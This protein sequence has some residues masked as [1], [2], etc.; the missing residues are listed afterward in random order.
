MRECGVFEKITVENPVIF[1]DV[2]LA[3][4]KHRERR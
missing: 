3:R 2:V 4:T 1:R